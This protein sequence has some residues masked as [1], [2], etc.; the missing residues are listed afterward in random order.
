MIETL[1]PSPRAHARP[2]HAVPYSGPS[3]FQRCLAARQLA[4]L[5]QQQQQG[6]LSE[7]LTGLL[8]PLLLATADDPSPSVQ[9]YGHAGVVTCGEPVLL[10]EMHLGA[11]RPRDVLPVHPLLLLRPPQGWHGSACAV[12]PPSCTGRRRCCALSCSGS[13]SA[14]TRRAGRLPCQPRRAW[15][16]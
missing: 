13:S 4:W 16:W 9:R 1:N 11:R 3:T 6:S 15:R 12:R 8:L 10:T 2:P 7:D 14:A 5:V